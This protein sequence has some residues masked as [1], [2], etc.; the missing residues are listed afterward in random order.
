[1]T[2]SKAEERYFG[3]IDWQKKLNCNVR[4]VKYSWKLVL[5]RL[6]EIMINGK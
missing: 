1:M 4:H 5:E 3:R 2:S 6:A